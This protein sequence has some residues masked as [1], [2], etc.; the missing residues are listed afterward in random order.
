MANTF[1]HSVIEQLRARAAADLKT[2]YLPESEDDRTLEA[3]SLLYG[4]SLVKVGLIGDPRRIAMRVERGGWA[5][6]DIPV[7]DPAYDPHREE[8]IEE[9]FKLRRHKGLTKDQAVEQLK[10]PLFYANM[11]VRAGR[12]DGTVAGATNTTAHTVRAALLCLGLQK[13]LKTVSSFFVM[14]KQGASFGENGAMLFA[15]C[16]VVIDPSSEQLVEIAMATAQSCRQILQVEPRIALLSFSTKGSAKHPAVDKVTH[17][18]ETLKARAPQLLVD[19][20]LQLDAALIPAVAQS[21]APGSAV[22]GKAN[23]LIFPDLQSGNIGYKIAERMG[24][25][26]AVG[27]ILQGLERPSNDLS[28]GCKAADIVDAAVITALQA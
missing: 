18:L 23:V 11:M 12:A 17:A 6:G 16:G 8:Y 10:D 5:W 7:V 21:K 13:G 9:F 20:E 24:G 15:D 27:P 3:A 1:T 26:T 4:R 14:E 19:G 2:I 25:Y 28:R 22:A